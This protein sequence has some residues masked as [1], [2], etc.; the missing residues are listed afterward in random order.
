M[1]TFYSRR[2]MVDSAKKIL[3]THVKSNGRCA[4]CGADRCPQR[5]GA[6]RLLYSRRYAPAILR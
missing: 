3:A 1:I 5:A 6:I 4:A 2:G